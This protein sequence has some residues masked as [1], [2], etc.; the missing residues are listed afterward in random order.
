[1]GIGDW[2]AT[3]KGKTLLGFAYGW[4]AMIVIVGALFKIQHWPGAGPML[5]VGLSTEAVIFFISAFEKVH[6]DL[7]WS[8]VY[9]EL[10]HHEEHS[11]EVDGHGEDIAALPE[12]DKGTVTEQLDKMLEEAKIGPELIESLGMGLVGLKDQAAK[13]TELTDASVA[14]EEFVSNVKGASVSAGHLS[15]TFTNSASQLSE[16]LNTSANQLSESFT[17]SAS[18]LSEKLNTSADQLSATINASAQE[19]VVNQSKTAE[20]FA[21]SAS[22]LT[23]KLSSSADQLTATLNASAQDIVL[24]QSKTAEAL[25]NSASQLSEKLNATADQLSTTLHASA[26]DLVASQS[27]SAESLAKSASHLSDTYIKASEHIHSEFL[28]ENGSSYREQ[29]QHVTQNL[30][31][32]NST[33]EIQLRSVNEQLESTGKLYEGIKELMLNLNESIADT[34]KYRENMSEL[35]KNLS[36]LNTVY[37]NMLSAMNFNK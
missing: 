37:G 2:M 23:E 27:K 14:T 5:I 25:S 21:H 11:D 8:L 31:S 13:L 36:S 17:N 4:G 15:E 9:P 1:M 19:M 28:A 30:S 16:T 3:K 6:E 33:Y 29:M 35:S 12:E 34:R 24:S 22:L 26:Q 32:L 20:K 7:D 10:A 18:Q